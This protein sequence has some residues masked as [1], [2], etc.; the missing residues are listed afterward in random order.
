[1]TNVTEAKRKKDNVELYRGC[2]LHVFKSAGSTWRPGLGLRGDTDRQS[3]GRSARDKRWTAEG[4]VQAR[5]GP[6]CWRSQG[7]FPRTGHR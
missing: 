3:G 4:P 2:R 7:R 1:M 5:K 6:M